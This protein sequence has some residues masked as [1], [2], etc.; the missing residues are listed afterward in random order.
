MPS[1][2]LRASLP[3]PSGGSMG[4]DARAVANFFIE[5]ACREQHILTHLA[6]QK[7]LF[8]AHAWH[9]AKFDRPLIGQ[10]FEAWQYGPVIRVVYDQ[11]KDL[12]KK[13]IDRLLN[14]IDIN[15][16]AWIKS[17][18]HFSEEEN[19]FLSGLFKY[20]SKF[21]AGTLVD[22]THDKDGP[23]EK[24]W[25]MSV[26]NAVPGMAIPNQNI[27]LWILRGGGRGVNTH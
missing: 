20:Y 18:Y 10:Q 21:H 6:L 1:S 24:I 25:N 23:W 15:S 7:I 19:L 4:H 9:L 27:K 3:P 2:R 11:L 22:L 14:K 16:G 13:P 8:F 26:D 17:D 5:T 12:K